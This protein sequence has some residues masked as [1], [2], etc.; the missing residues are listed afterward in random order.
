M[1]MNINDFTE[2]NVSLAPFTSWQIGG[3]AEY[4]SKP[5]N[6]NELKEI[7]IWSKENNKKIFPLS[8]G[9]NVLVSDE[10]ISGVVLL[11]KN[12]SGITSIEE[13][14]KT[15]HLSALAGTSKSELLKILLKYNSSAALFL[16][17]IPGDVGGGVVM[18]AGI[19]EKVSPREFCEVVSWIKVIDFQGKEKTH[20]NSDLNWTYRHCLGWEPGVIYEVGFR[21]NIQDDPEILNKVRD[22]NRLR[23]Q[24]QPLDMPSC[25]SVFMNPDGHRAAQLID[26]CGLKGLTIGQA[27]VS[28]KHANFIVNLGGASAKDTMSLIQ[29]VQFEVKKKFN[30]DLQVECQTL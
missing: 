5:R 8:G 2:K 11:F 7:L 4:L 30:I 12:L 17:G 23:L 1:N 28:L 19:S 26:Q 24:K 29:R 21:F 13:E 18:N 16:A 10:G 22:A 25:G 15:L 20:C 27:Q 9:S 14:G 3:P 6:I